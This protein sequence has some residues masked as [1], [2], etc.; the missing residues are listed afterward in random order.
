ML[1]PA[2]IALALLALAGPAHAEAKRP[3]VVFLLSDDQRFDT[4]AALG[5]RDVHTPNLDRLVRE[6]HAFTHCHIMGSTVP[7]VCAPS[8]AMLMS[9]R[10]LYRAPVDLPAPLPLL[11][12][13]LRK[14][15]YTT[16]AVGKWHNGRASFHR[17][18][19]GGENIFFGGMADHRRVPVHAYDP[20]GRYAGKPKPGGKFSSELFA[21]SAVRFLRSHKG[22]RP[23]FLYVAFTA[24]HDPRIPP[25]EFARRYD[26]AR[27]PLP[28]S[29]LP[30]HP[31][32]NGEMT[33]RDEKLLP[34][35]RTPAAIREQT[36]AYYGM[37]T[38]LDAQVGRILAALAEAG[39]E[40]DTLVVFASDNGLAL[41]RHGLL[42]KQSLYD[43]SVRVPL[44]L[45]G[46]GVPAG[47]RSPAL[48]YLLDLFP[49]LCEM[50]K[51]PAP[52]GLEGE[53]LVPIL[54]GKRAQVR[55][56]VFAAYRDVQR[57]VRTERWK[58][59]LYPKAGR[60]QLFDLARDPDEVRDLSGEPGQ[61]GRVRELTGLLRGWQKKV[62]DGL[63]LPAPA[64]KPRPSA[65]N[66]STGG[67]RVVVR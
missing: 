50:T 62:G 13:V 51:A 3:N 12:E 58:L 49:T 42:G 1:R 34:W 4:I 2:L 16:Y 52:R 45:R 63:A 44:V 35:P 21:D 5:N 64:S 54:S 7:A 19:A 32:D 25:P 14:A 33:I 65:K 11:P 30:R 24:P 23:F 28:A 55:D 36:T 60:V 26:P 10:T 43:H 37:I 67:E 9:G 6:G 39:L 48:V 61:A 47:K 18:F 29:F 17:A 40:K 56:S 31:F 38:H 20:T 53:S 46:P 57:M 59:I 15:G 22:D 27:L 66:A 8:R 41:G